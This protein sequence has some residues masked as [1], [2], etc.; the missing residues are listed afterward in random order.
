MTGKIF[1]EW[2]IWFNLQ[3]TGRK[4]LLLIDGFSAHKAG[5]ALLQEERIELQNVTILFLPENA[6]SL[7]QPLD[8][9]IIWTWKAY[10]QCQ[11][12]NF[13]ICEFEAE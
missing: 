2:L 11:W 10:Y 4:V 5:I 1:R 6:T 12:L 13:A 9:G 8:Q 7:C 3:M